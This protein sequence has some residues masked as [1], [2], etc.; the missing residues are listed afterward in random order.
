V[1]VDAWA[2]D[3]VLGVMLLAIGV[4]VLA[5]IPRAVL[6]AWWMRVCGW[7]RDA[8]IRNGGAAPRAVS[9]RGE[10]RPGR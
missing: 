9:G 4:G 1:T 3:L 5:R 7:E 6:T 10:P 2:T 8:A